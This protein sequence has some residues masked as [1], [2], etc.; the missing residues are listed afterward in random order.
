MLNDSIIEIFDEKNKKCRL[1]QNEDDEV[2]F[3][4]LNPTQR[5]ICFLAIDHCVFTKRDGFKKCDCAVFDKNTFCFIEIKDSTESS[6]S[7]RM[8]QGRDQLL[9]SIDKFAEQIDFE[10][11]RLE[12]YLCMGISDEI[13]IPNLSSD[14]QKDLAFEMRNVELYRRTNKKEFL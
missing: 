10:N 5:D 13:N 2:H 12:A 7:N 9:S 11:V 4:V 1:K 6:L 3:T 8:K 14:L